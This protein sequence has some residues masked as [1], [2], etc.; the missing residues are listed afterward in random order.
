MPVIASLAASL[1]VLAAAPALARACRAGGIQIKSLKPLA[2]PAVHDA[3]GGS[4]FH[5]TTHARLQRLAR[6]C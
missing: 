4:Q 2:I 1:A 3:R 6:Y 5:Q